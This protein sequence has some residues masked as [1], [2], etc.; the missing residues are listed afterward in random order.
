MHEFINNIN[1]HINGAVTL[2]LNSSFVF[3][4]FFLGE[5]RCLERPFADRYFYTQV[6][7]LLGL[8]MRLFGP[9]GGGSCRARSNGLSLSSPDKFLGRKH[10]ARAEEEAS[11]TSA[12]E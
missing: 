3:V 2:R 5:S 12:E 1:I 7:L 8:N 4:P 6:L 10:E 9:V 11:T